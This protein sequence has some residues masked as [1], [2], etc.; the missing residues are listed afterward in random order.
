MDGGREGGRQ[1]GCKE[2]GIEGDL[3][4]T[5]GGRKRENEGETERKT[6][7]SLEVRTSASL[8]HSPGH[9]NTPPPRK[10]ICNEY[11]YIMIGLCPLVTS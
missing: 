8:C 3:S 4:Q 9:H 2:R 6:E 5:K 1:E 11:T 10:L 7:S